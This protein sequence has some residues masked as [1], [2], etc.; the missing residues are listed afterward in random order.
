[1]PSVLCVGHAVQDFVFAVPALPQRAEKHRAS[2]FEVVGGGPA[3]TASVAVARLGGHARLAARLGDDA[4][5]DLIIAELESFGVDCSSMRRFPGCRSSVSSVLVDGDGARSIVNYLDPMLPGDAGWISQSL[6]DD[7]DVVLADTRW[8]DGARHMLQRA[9][10]AG[11]PAVLDADKPV[12]KDAALLDSATHIA[13][14][15]EGL[16]DFA[17][18]DAV[19]M[20]Q[21]VARDTG[22]WC[23]VTRGAHGVDIATPAGTLHVAAFPVAVIDTLGAGDVWHGA[24]ALSLAEGRDELHA[25]RF[26][27]AAAALKVQRFG[28]R[29]GVPDRAETDRF[30]EARA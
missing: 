5:A 6:L 24:F 1:M 3:A 11:R 30:L 13:F 4:I 20:L 14:S 16:A 2:A 18:D 25:V 17:G 7:A 29:A 9:K 8:P 15:A 12:P 27:N 10:Q 22:A 28:G 19:A 26:A 21:Q 23:C